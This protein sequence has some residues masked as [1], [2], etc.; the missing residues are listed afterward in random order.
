MS[1]LWAAV[2]LISVYRRPPHY[3]YTRNDREELGMTARAST[4]QK[5]PAVGI[6]F[7][8][9]SCLSLQFGAAFAVHLFPLF[10][11]WLV[12]ALRLFLAAITVGAAVWISGRWRARRGGTQPVKPADS[13]K[14]S[15]G[16]LGWSAHQWR[17]MIIFG[18][19]LGFMNGF[20]YNALARIPLGLAVSV[21]FI[22]P[23]ALAS[24][25]T[26]RKSDLVW[27][28][29]AT[30]GMAVLGFEAAHGHDTDLLGILYALIAG[31]FWALYIRSSASVGE[32]VPGASGLAV[33]M[34]V[35][36][37]CM[38]PGTLLFPGPTALWDVAHD[39]QLVLFIIGTSLLASVVPYSSELAALRHLP[40]Q[41]FSVLL[42][43]EPA[44]AAL[45]GWALL[46]QETGLMRWTAIV[47]LVTASIGITRAAGDASA[48]SSA[49]DAAEPSDSS[50]RDEPPE[51]TSPL[52]LPE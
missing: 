34:A 38:I 26:R 9:I 50:R 48:G 18:L 49:A 30:A 43:L 37:V 1:E 52:P 2:P 24:I 36:A 4:G 3:S 32:L 5:R 40:Q 29:C 31:A 51:H 23:L 41:V 35:G 11:P 27:V 33:A 42:S 17:A 15:G 46:G 39:T 20:F 8:M 6:I 28:F 22:G 14:A 25:L 19:T 7:V 45:A 47:L 44:I 10:G 21:E 16:F 12:T 13:A